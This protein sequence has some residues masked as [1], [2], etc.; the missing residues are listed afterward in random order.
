MKKVLF[1]LAAVSV[2]ALCTSCGKECVCTPVGDFW[3]QAEADGFAALSV[4]EEVC[5]LTGDE[6]LDC[7]WE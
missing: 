2:L 6:D 3:T 4:T 7:K 5:N 1:T